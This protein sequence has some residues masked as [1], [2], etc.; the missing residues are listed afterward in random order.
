MTPLFLFQAAGETTGMWSTLLMFGLMFLVLYFLMI[1][2]QQKRQKEH[3][4]MLETLQ[5]GDRVLTGSG[6]I[7]QI[8]GMDDQTFTIEIAKNTHVKFQK[9]AITGK[10]DALENNASK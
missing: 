8:S 10:A 6:M 3:K 2:P 1:R 9:A 5:P 7:G 4:N